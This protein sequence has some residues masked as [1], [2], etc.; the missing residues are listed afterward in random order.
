MATA[1]NGKILRVDLSEGR[2]WPEELPEVIYRRYLGG[3]ALACYFLLK[4]LKPGVDPLGP[5]NLLVFT[6]SVAT[7][8]GIS[9]LNRFTAAAKS[10]LTGGYGEAEAGGWWGPELKAAGFDGIIISGRAPKPVYLLVADGKAELRDASRYWGKLSGEVQDGLEAELG[11]KRI[12]VLQ[13]GIAGENRVRFAAIVNQLKHFN[14]RTGLGA[15]MASKNLKAIV[16]RGHKRPE[17]ASKERAN[18][19]LRWF[20]VHYDR[21]SDAVHKFGTARVVLTLEA[22]GILPTR[23]FR[24]GSF[25][26]A[27]DISGQRMV[28]T[29]L[30]DRGTC[31]ACAITCKREVE[32]PEL[33]VTP[34]YGGPEYETIAATG[35]LC[36]IG[37]LKRIARFNQLLNQYVL[38]SI[39]TGVVIAFAMECFEH[40]LLTKEDTG[41]LELRFGNAEAVEPLI[42]MIARREG[43][44]DLLAEGVK[45]AAAK[46]GR[47]AER[48]A[49]HVKGQEVPMHEPRGKKGLA[50]AYATSP[51]GADHMEAPHDPFYEGFHPKGHPLGALG[52][53]EP[54]DVLDL[55]PRKVRAFYYCQQV[56]SLYNSVGMCDLAGVPINAFPLDQLVHYVNAVTGWDTSLFELLKVGERANTMMRLFNYREGFTKDDDTLPPRL[57]EGLENGAHQGERIDPEEFQRALRLYY[58][59]CG[60][61][62]DTGAPTPAK[63]IELELDWAA[64]GRT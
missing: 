37:D 47:G 5:E 13:T 54:I 10:P 17:P 20:K 55:G 21:E 63:L 34:R 56:W 11:D 33:G 19:I 61:D 51:T 24:Q 7:G 53:I 28:E 59:L 18:E 23:N 22:N 14:G 42:H 8:L 16:A 2:V 9:G 6:T 15:V 62:P 1:Y 45:R 32:V 52:L 29:I 3:G 12:R 46:I 41:G 35:S 40:G 43:I 44:G 26:H 36:G 25:E 31:Y 27:R 60:W 57:F 38:D 58:Q 30:T 48:F 39:S 50:L 49:M 4:E 64:P